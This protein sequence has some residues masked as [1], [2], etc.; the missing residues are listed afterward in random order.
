RFFVLQ[1][2]WK[3]GGAGMLQVPSVPQWTQVYKFFAFLWLRK[4][5]ALQPRTFKDLVKTG[6]T[7]RFALTVND[8]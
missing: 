4:S 1:A 7:A 3:R 2:S 8:Q 5:I 6:R